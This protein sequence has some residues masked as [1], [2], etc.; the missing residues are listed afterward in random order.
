MG[1][2]AVNILDIHPVTLILVT[3]FVVGPTMYAFGYQ[4]CREQMHRKFQREAPHE[5]L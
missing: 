4:R 1:G 3:A 5:R 2:A